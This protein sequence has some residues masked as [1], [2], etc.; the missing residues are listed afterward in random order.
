MGALAGPRPVRAGRARPRPRL[1]RSP[2]PARRSS[3][4]GQGGAPV[5]GQALVAVCPNRAG[6]A[7]T[8]VAAGTVSSPS[9]Q[10]QPWGTT[11]VRLA[12]RHLPR[13]FAITSHAL[14][15]MFTPALLDWRIN[16]VC[17]TGYR[18]TKDLRGQGQSGNQ[19]SP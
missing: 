2:L 6:P 4:P 18:L 16:K 17:D 11:T 1:E 19:G 10:C 7:G 8:A 12:G 3:K 14:H 5:G 15:A 9:V 13:R